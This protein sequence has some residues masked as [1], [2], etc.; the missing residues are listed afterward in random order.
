MKKNT[1]LY[2]C[3]TLCLLFGMSSCNNQSKSPKQE[4]ILVEKSEAT[5][6]PDDILHE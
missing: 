4:K 6:V 1:I 3:T 5:A 2:A